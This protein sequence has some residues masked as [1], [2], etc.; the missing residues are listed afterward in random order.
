[1]DK[2][3][4]SSQTVLVCSK[5]RCSDKD[6]GIEVC[7]TCGKPHCASCFEI[8]DSCQKQLCPRG[9]QAHIETGFAMSAQTFVVC[10]EC[11]TLPQWQPCSYCDEP[12]G[13]NGFEE[14]SVC[15]FKVCPCCDGE[16]EFGRRTAEP[17]TRCSKCGAFVCRDC[18]PKDADPDEF[19][20]KLCQEK[21]GNGE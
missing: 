13:D 1:M 9:G 17:L 19:V 18:L 3:P 12:I 15:G 8:C 14:C 20:C 16:S 21:V 5:C 11:Q 4:E 7:G 2:T 10:K 6:D